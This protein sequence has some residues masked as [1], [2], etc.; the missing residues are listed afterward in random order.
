MYCRPGADPAKIVYAGVGKTDTEI[1]EAFEAGIGYFNIESE[2]ELDNLIRLAKKKA[3]IAIA[4]NPRRPCASTPTWTIRPT[5]FTATVSQGDQVRRR[6]RTGSGGLRE[7]GDNPAVELLRLHVH[8][9]TGGKTIDPYTS[10]R[11]EKILVLV[12]RLRT[13]GTKVEAL[14]LGGGYGADYE[15]D[16]VPSAVNTPRGLCRC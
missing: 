16:T 10:K 3:V 4:P 11:V 5:K 2:Q 9:G 1:V 6:Y 12:D 15:T 14:D 7:Y 13:K 8:L